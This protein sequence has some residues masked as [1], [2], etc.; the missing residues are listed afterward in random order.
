M[1]IGA[2]SHAFSIIWVS[3]KRIDLIEGTDTDAC[4]GIGLFES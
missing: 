1:V 2:S 3:V 4:I